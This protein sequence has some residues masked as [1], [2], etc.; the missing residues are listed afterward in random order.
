MDKEL[1]NGSPSRQYYDSMI[2]QISHQI[3]RVSEGGAS[4]QQP[5]NTIPHKNNSNA[6]STL[7]DEENEWC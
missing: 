7:D 3:A 4:S 2:S 5:F 1:I 6:P